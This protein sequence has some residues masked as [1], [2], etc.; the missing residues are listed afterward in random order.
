M[1]WIRAR[2]AE[3][4]VDAYG[5]F[6]ERLMAINDRISQLQA[7]RARRVVALRDSPVLTIVDVLLSQ[8]EGGRR[9]S[10]QLQ[11]EQLQQLLLQDGLESTEL[12]NIGWSRCWQAVAAQPTLDVEDKVL[13]LQADRLFH[14]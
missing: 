5:S 3:T 10:E 7:L 2:R 11:P 6:L 13:S 9:P 1:L 4:F 14:V 8:D 12:A